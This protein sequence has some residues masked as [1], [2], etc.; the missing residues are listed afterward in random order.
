MSIY[1]FQDEA[2]GRLRRTVPISIILFG[3]FVGSDVLLGNAE[4]AR[5]WP[6]LV[7][8]CSALLGIGYFATK[9]SWPRFAL[10]LLLAA[11]LTTVAGVIMLIAVR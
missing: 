3:L 2:Y 6:S 5:L 10:G 8:L 4:G 7:L 11:V 1:A 9:K